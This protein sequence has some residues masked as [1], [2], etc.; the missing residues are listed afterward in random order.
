MA[1]KLTIRRVGGFLPALSL[2]VV[3]L[4]STAIIWLSVVGLPESALRYIEE[5]LDNQGIHLRLRA[6]KLEPSRGLA[7]RA[8][9]IRFFTKAESPAPLVTADSFSVGINASRL[10]TGVLS[11]DTLHLRNG[12]I[13]LPTGQEG[14]EPLELSHIDLSAR[15]T[16]RKIARLTSAGMQIQGIPVRLRGAYDL[17]QL[18]KELEASEPAEAAAPS[19][20]PDIDAILQEHAKTFATIRR[21][22]T[23]QQWQ[24]DERPSLELQLSAAANKTQ[25]GLQLTV[26]RYDWKQFHFR[27]ATADIIYKDDT[28][29]VHSMRFHT[30]D[31]D[32]T[33]SLQCGFV[34]PERALSFSLNSNADLLN[35]VEPFLGEETKQL[36][37]KFSYP[38]DKAPGIS[39]QGDITFAE[40][41]APDQARIRGSLNSE[42]LAIGSEQV[43]KLELS[44]LYHNGDFN[45]DK[46]ALS[47][48]N[49]S[50]DMTAAARQGQGEADAHADVHV[51]DL[52]KLINQFSKEPIT[53]PQDLQLHGNVKLTAQAKLTTLPLNASAEDWENFVPSCSHVLVKLQTDKISYQTYELDKPDIQV[54]INN[55]VQGRNKIP[56]SVQSIELDVTAAAICNTATDS[57][58]KLSDIACNLHCNQLTIKD[59]EPYIE[60][61]RIKG[62]VGQWEAADIHIA[63]INLS[64]LQLSGL[65]PQ[66]DR[67][68]LFRSAELEADTGIITHAGTALGQASLYCHL[69]QTD[70]GSI[71][72]EL[73]NDKN[74]K[75]VVSAGTDWSKPNQWE[76]NDIEA[77]IP[78][79]DFAPL[80]KH[81][82]LVTQDFEYPERLTARGSCIWDTK[83]ARLESAQV[84]L[85]IPEIVRTPHK[86]VPFQGKRIPIGLKADAHLKSAPEGGIAYSA[87]VQITHKTGEFKGNIAGNS[88]SHLR[89]TGNSSI[90]VDVIDQLI[91]NDDAHGIIRDFRFG[92]RSRTAVT[93]IDTNVRYDNG[94]TVRSYCDALIE[95]AEYMLSALCERPNKTEYLRTDLGSNPYTYTKRATCG[96]VVDVRLDSQDAK[97][98]K[99]KDKICITLTNPRLV[100]DNEPWLKRQKFITGTAETTMGGEAVIID[101]ENS[102]VELR[103]I[104]GN[105]YPA[106]SLGMFYGDIQH[107][108]ADIVLPRPAQVETVNC[109]FPIYSDCKRPMSGTIRVLSPDGAAFNF[110][111]TSIPLADFSGFIYLTND[112]VQL[113]KL[114]AKSW[115]GVLDALVRIGFRGKHTSF[116]GYVKASNMD[117]HRIAAAYGSVQAYA[118]CNGYIRFRTP[119]PEVKDVQGYGEIDITNGDLLTL[120]L[121]RPVGSYIADLPSNLTQLEQLANKTGV[122]EEPGFF[123]RM[124]TRMFSALERTVNKMG[125]SV[126]KITYYIPGANHI[127]SYDLQE[128][129]ARFNIANGHLVTSGMKAKGHNLN[130]EMNLDI[131]LD[132]MLINANI[133]PKVSSLPT[134]ILSPLTFLSDFMV[135]IV[136]HGP[137]DDLDWHFALDRRLH[138]DTPSATDETPT[139][140]PAPVHP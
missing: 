67:Q 15:L 135:D 82:G 95:N 58:F 139:D 105:V 89:V 78:P 64:K 116:D 121:F 30:V 110:L 93:N 124:L 80:L 76:I 65:S 87:D 48:P 44:F 20:L 134:I 83:N 45:V 13:T 129:F 34:I 59:T 98:A 52:L 126:D 90:R 101:V 68:H 133:W 85:N 18:S 2:V 94:V 120:S 21:H 117:L 42:Q 6:L 125:D 35:L 62:S 26:P 37:Q 57:P 103:N 73:V 12:R 71:N 81:F 86:L 54:S 16:R 123:S 88:D 111:G 99:L 136:V 128:A 61:L 69:P 22:I 122:S 23:T 104:S 74:S 19:P 8:E 112:Y 100:Y 118:L 96:V 50:A 36:L 70:R 137:I 55:I 7:F 108:L 140:N 72:A 40:N 106:Y 5:Q 56:E 9:G 31:P 138:M 84:Q 75:C 130:V 3:L 32:S 119:S 132:N 66:A 115:G 43:D 39:L 49:G 41:G 131:N 33:A 63:G 14:S 92:A 38:A 4:C 24:P 28:V 47:F 77:Y 53:L 114:N 29:T 10:L 11:A 107:F 127:L 102:F 27:N 17:N 97:G 51:G 46:L 79:A 1:N 109:V 60:T 25:Y 91:D 113:D